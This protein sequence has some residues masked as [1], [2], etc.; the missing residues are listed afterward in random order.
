MLLVARAGSKDAASVAQRGLTLAPACARNMFAEA[1]S[2]I[3]SQIYVDVI[4]EHQP[5]KGLGNA[6]VKPNEIPNPDQN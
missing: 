3:Q 6:K 5:R 4:E 1:I 2:N